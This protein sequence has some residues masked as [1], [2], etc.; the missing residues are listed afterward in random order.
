[1]DQ[2]SKDGEYF[3]DAIELGNK[4]EETIDDLNANKKIDLEKVFKRVSGRCPANLRAG[5]EVLNFSQTGE[6]VPCIVFT[7]TGD[8]SLLRKKAGSLCL[9]VDLIQPANIVTVNLHVIYLPLSPEQRNDIKP[10]DFNDGLEGEILQISDIEK[11]RG[12]NSQV[13]NIKNLVVSCI[14]G[15]IQESSSNNYGF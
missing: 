2:A 3:S 14:K 6:S 9:A 4:A 8:D 13:E 11:V 7:P 15:E 10:R 12:L 1:M 5:T